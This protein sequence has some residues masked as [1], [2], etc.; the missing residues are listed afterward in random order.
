LRKTYEDLFKTYSNPL[1]R[2]NQDLEN[3]F[4]KKEPSLKKAT[5]EFY[6]STFKILC[7]FAD[8]GAPPLEIEVAGKE[9]E[10][11]EKVIKKG[12]LITEGVTI[13]LNIQITL[14]VTDD[15]E[16]YDKIFK[17]LKEHIFSRS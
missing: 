15:A 17:A 14:P 7:E 5:L 2:S 13:N 6:V 10:K 12:E 1:E 11:V 16:V 9:G 4:A 3:I 8:F